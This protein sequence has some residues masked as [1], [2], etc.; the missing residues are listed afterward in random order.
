MEH[1]WKLRHILLT[2]MLTVVL[3]LH[4]YASGCDHQ[5]EPRRQEPGCDKSG[6]SWQECIYC[7]DVIDYLTIDP[8][9][10]TFDVWY[11]T[12]EPTCTQNGIQVRDCV[13]CGFQESS[14]VSHLGHDYVVEVMPPSCTAR[15]YTSHYCP[16]CGD[17]FR[18]EYTE[19]LG[20][21]YD[22][23][24]VIKEP[25]LTTMGRIRYTCSGCGDTYQDTIPKLVNP[26]TDIDKNAYYFDP[27]IWA[28]NKGITSG[29]DNTHFGPDVL[30]NRAQVVTF[31]WRSAGMPEPGIR[32]NPFLD[33]PGGSFYEKAVLWAFEEKIT[34]GTDSTHFSPDLPCNRAQV[35]TF[36]HRYRGCPESQGTTQFPDVKAGNFFYHAVL[37]AAQRGIT[38]GMDDGYF[39]PEHNCNRAQIVTFLYRD[40]YNP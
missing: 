21:R 37:W 29:L 6:M 40:T 39:R 26:F 18:T 4:V 5:Y 24:V 7:G 15:G 16:G 14:T 34:S 27:V 38:L 20:H 10:H 28:V 12:K 31:L 33:V 30:C 8:T 2:L 11:I 3:A 9:G 22:D 23:G 1:S 17:R 36:L 32:Q 35:V 25:T 19:A 13:I